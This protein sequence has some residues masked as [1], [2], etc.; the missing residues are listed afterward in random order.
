MNEIQQQLD[1]LYAQGLFFNCSNS[2]PD[3]EYSVII[4]KLGVVYEEPTAIHKDLETA[5][6]L[7]I[8]KVKE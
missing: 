6:I 4:G 7:A 3:G 5:I 2:D 1:K 8:K